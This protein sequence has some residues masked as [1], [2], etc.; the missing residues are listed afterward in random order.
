MAGSRLNGP[1]VQGNLPYRSK[2]LFSHISNSIIPTVAT[3]SAPC[4]HAYNRNPKFL[5]KQN[6]KQ[7]PSWYSH[8]REQRAQSFEKLDP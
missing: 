4:P 8:T 5:K 1:A 3:I 2:P 7:T 6:P